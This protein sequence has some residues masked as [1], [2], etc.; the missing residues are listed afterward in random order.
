[1]GRSCLGTVAYRPQT[2]NQSGSLPGP[3]LGPR[4]SV[5]SGRRYGRGGRG[6]IAAQMVV[7]DLEK[8]SLAH[9][10][11]G[12]DLKQIIGRANEKIRQ[13]AGV[14]PALEGMGTTATVVLVGQDTVYWAHVGD[15]RLYLFQTGSLEQI[16]R[17]QTFIQDFIEDGTMSQEE[18]ERHPLRNVLE[19]CVGCSGLEVEIGSFKFMTEDRLLLCSDGLIRHLSDDSIK[20]VLEEE[21]TARRAVD[22]LVDQA[23]KAGGE[24]NVT[25]VVMDL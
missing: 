1:M 13:R 21:S 24:D 15:S 11:T 4:G 22:K 10:V 8:T 17:D 6:D 7:A 19:Q 12:H 20:A 5:G 2:E 23:L 18:A 16:S 3:P 9:R 14:D 25:V